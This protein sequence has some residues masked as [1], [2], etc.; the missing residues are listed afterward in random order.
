M[1]P[2]KKSST[3]VITINGAH[4]VPIR[5]QHVK[6]ISFEGITYIPVHP[7]P[8]YVDT[9]KAI[10]NENECS[11]TNTFKIG[12]KTYIPISVIP[13]VYRAI[14]K[15][16]V[17]PANITRKIT[18]VISI[19]GNHFVPI[20]NKTVKPIVL[21]GVTYLPV[22]KA[23]YYLNVKKPISPKVEGHINTFAF[24]NIT[25]IPIHVIPKTYL[26]IFKNIP[27]KA[28]PK[29]V[30]KYEIS[31]NGKTY[32]PITNSTSKHL[33][34]NGKVYIPVQRDKNSVIDKIVIT[35]NQADGQINTF[36]IG[37]KTY[38][39]LSVVPKV[40]K[41]VF[42]Y[43][44]TLP[45]EKGPKQP[46]IIKINNLNFIPVADKSIKPV[47]VDNKIFVPVRVA[48]DHFNVSK[49]IEPKKKGEI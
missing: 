31:I 43:K 36:K 37:S 25:Y 19:N 45:A 15:N 3:P 13:K 9:S 40:F 6:E 22:H 5:G 1:T 8:K 18:T 47:V 32:K 29:S 38:I 46:P 34:I 23:P 16:K 24:G 41:A 39:P 14:F 49:S 26:P 44:V 33:V 2:I 27:V 17:R 30:N 10:I 42:A 7:A 20:T 4:F 28:T 11:I 35:P 48:P 21:E 12:S